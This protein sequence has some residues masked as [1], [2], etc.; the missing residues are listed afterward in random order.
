[1]LPRPCGVGSDIALSRVDAGWSFCRPAKSG[2]VRHGEKVKFYELRVT[3]VQEG[4]GQ[5]MTARGVI[6][7]VAG[8]G[9]RRHWKPPSTLLAVEFLHS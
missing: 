6:C 3:S 5:V 9:P 4:Q 1:M 8:M 7:R 2:G